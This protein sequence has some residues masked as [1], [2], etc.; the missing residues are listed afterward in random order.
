MVLLLRLHEQQGEE[1]MFGSPQ[2][3]GL[4]T[5]ALLFA[6]RFDQAAECIE[7]LSDSAPSRRHCCNGN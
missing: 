1:L 2:L 7:Q 5:A 6:G 4:I 3:V